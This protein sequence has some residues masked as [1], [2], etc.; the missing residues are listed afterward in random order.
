[1]TKYTLPKLTH[2]TALAAERLPLVGEDAVE[3]ANADA[4]GQLAEGFGELVG[5]VVKV[6][7][8]GN[9]RE[10]FAAADAVVAEHAAERAQVRCVNVKQF[11]LVELHFHRP[12][13]RY[14]SHPGAAI[15][16][17]QFLEVA[18]VARQHRPVDV[19]S[20]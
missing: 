14:D 7:C 20:A 3:V 10:E 18:E 12:P 17:Q 4:K 15:V 19:I 11:V 8:F 1:V 6:F 9:E 2:K 13:S 16:R 5:R